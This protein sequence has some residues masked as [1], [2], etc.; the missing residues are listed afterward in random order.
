MNFP[1]DEREARLLFNLTDSLGPVRFGRLVDRFGSAAAALLAGA[2]AWGAVE[3]FGEKAES[4][5][6][7]VEK[8]L[9]ALDAEKANV[10]RLGARVLCS[11]DPEYPDGFRR[12]RDA[13]PVLYVWGELKP[14]DGLGVAVVGSRRPSHYGTAAAERLARELAQSGVT[15][16]SGLA[17]GIDGSAHAA[18]LSAGGR[19][20]GLLGSGF[21]KFYP[22][23]HRALADRMA[24]NGAVVT[25]FPLQADPEA[26]HFPRRNRL[27]A[28][29]SLGLV[30]VEALERSGALITAGLAADQG[31]EVFAV[32][33]SIFSPLSRGPHRLIKNGAKPVE[34][35][36]D[37]LEDI[38]V[39]RDL[40]DRAP[41]TTPALPLPALGEVSENGRKLLAGVSL[42]P[43]GI[44]GLARG[45]G[46]TA[47]QAARELLSL[48]V[49]GLVRAVPGKQYIRSERSLISVG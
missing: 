40:M 34:G 1:T 47:A 11:L 26:A 49:A 17:R 9:P 8:G 13:P 37:V 4:Y 43:A 33:G 10:G 28:A 22:A 2:E 14:V 35:A 31:K 25:E 21:S 38:G 36:M 30:V 41:L 20:V 18:S 27:I 46:L 19:T 32:P 6:R 15:V 24:K 5:F 45:A 23:E 16:V 29:L 48:E 39:F 7:E 42:E 12:L 44:D 3:G